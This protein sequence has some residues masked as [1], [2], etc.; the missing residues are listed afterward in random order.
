MIEVKISLELTKN[1]IQKTVFAKAG[2]HGARRIIINL[3]CNGKVLDVSD[4]A[5]DMHM[6][7]QNGTEVDDY[8]E[9]CEKEGTGYAFSIPALTEGE[10]IF[11]VA[12]TKGEQRLYSPR[13][14]LYSEASYDAES[15]TEPGEPILYQ[16]ILANADIIEAV[17]MADDDY[18]IIYDTDLERPVKVLWSSLQYDDSELRQSMWNVIDRL[19]DA[20]SAISNRYTK[21]ETNTLLGA[22]VDKETGK[23]LSSN[24]FTDSYITAITNNTAAR[25]THS[26]KT[27]IDKFSEN[28]A[29]EPLYDG[30]PIGG[31][32]TPAWSDITGKPT[33]LA[34]YGVEEEVEQKISE[35]AVNS[36]WNENDTDSL[37]YIKNRT[38]YAETRTELIDSS[39]DG[40]FDAEN[41]PDLISEHTDED[42]QIFRVYKLSDNVEFNGET[43]DFDLKNLK[44]KC[45]YTDAYT[46]ISGIY[47]IYDFTVARVDDLIE[48]GQIPSNMREE[49]ISEFIED[50]DTYYQP[51]IEDTAIMSYY[52]IE[53]TS[54]AVIYVLDD[55]D[56]EIFGE[57]EHHYTKGVYAISIV[58]QY[59]D[60]GEYFTNYEFT[61]TALETITPLDEKY[62]PAETKQKINNL[63]LRLTAEEN[64]ILDIQLGIVSSGVVFYKYGTEQKLKYSDIYAA[65]VGNK[66]MRLMD[67]VN[68]IATDIKRKYDVQ[69][70][71]Y[72]NTTKVITLSVVSVTDEKISVTEFIVNKPFDEDKDDTVITGRT[73]QYEPNTSIIDGNNV[74]KLA[75]MKDLEAISVP[76]E[77]HIGTSA[78]TGEEI[79]WVDTDEDEE[80]DDVATLA[81][82]ATKISLPSNPQNGDLLMW[83]GTNWVARKYYES[84]YERLEYIEVA[85]A[86][87]VIEIPIS[88]G[89]STFNIKAKIKSVNRYSSLF[90][91]CY[92]TAY[93]HYYLWGSAEGIGVWVSDARKANVLPESFDDWIDV[94]YD[95]DGTT[96]TNTVNGV[97]ATYDYS[98]LRTYSTMTVF[99]RYAGGYDKGRYKLKELSATIGTKSF[100]F[101][102]VRNRFTNVVGLL[103]PETLTFYGNVSTGEIIAGNPM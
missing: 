64:K 18:A 92:N 2:E 73:Y 4:A 80:P 33:T 54:A 89:E 87:P 25:H 79:L 5:Y 49:A 58:N 83:N 24:D 6:L 41:A 43:F 53:E 14:R 71:K 37:A 8:A 42:E 101:V 98:G 40:D 30:E 9:F 15:W 57:G 10:R 67:S 102:P 75:T 96:I 3:T 72:D 22:K 69:L 66:S 19:T 77:V 12:I 97:S 13:F 23:G 48:G 68:I 52:G 32:G 34:G 65:Y 90:S 94:E 50:C 11:E 1:G 84:I 39:W 21:S 47:T 91:P 81:D 27:V 51:I 86:G 28:A 82:L 38:H 76:P 46:P 20:E 45:Y 44:Q 62:I 60:E 35:S 29:G 56:F 17:D 99:A 70:V 36:D 55:C 95:Y 88:Y 100:S 85:E 61:P 74:N 16:P 7:T 26:N 103:E 93:G 59:E 78:P 63:D 31:G